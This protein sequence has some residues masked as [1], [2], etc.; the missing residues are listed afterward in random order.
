[1][2]FPDTHSDELF[3]SKTED[4]ED[5]AVYEDDYWHDDYSEE[6]TP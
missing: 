5:P 4:E 2:I 6:S 3:N 1:M